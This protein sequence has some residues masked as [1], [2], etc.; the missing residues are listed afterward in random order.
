MKTRIGFVS[1]SSSS[2]FIVAYKKGDEVFDFRKVIDCALK[3]FGASGDM[4]VF[5]TKKKEIVR[6]FKAG[7]MFDADDDG[8]CEDNKIWVNSVVSKIKET[9]ELYWNFIM[10]ELSNN[11]ILIETI[12][13]EMERSGDLRF[14][15]NHC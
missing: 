3:C 14:F 9:D 13:K 7:W 10:F 11:D 2:N 6:E 5:E 4:E 12:M 8:E 1:N 15:L